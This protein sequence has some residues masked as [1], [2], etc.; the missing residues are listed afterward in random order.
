MARTKIFTENEASNEEKAY[1]VNAILSA[2]E[3]LS[4]VVKGNLD[5]AEPIFVVGG[6]S[7]RKTHLFEN[8]VHIKSN[9]LMI[10]EDLKNKIEAGNYKVGLL[11]GLA[12]ENEAEVETVLNTISVSKFFEDLRND[13]K[14]YYGC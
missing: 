12:L 11:K 10:S 9:R 14:A 5:N 6:L 8:V 4:L 13:V 3:N 7:E 2:I 1:R